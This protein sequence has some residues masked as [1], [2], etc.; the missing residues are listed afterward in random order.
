MERT[1]YRFSGLAN[2]ATV[3]AATLLAS[4][5]TFEQSGLPGSAASMAHNQIMLVRKEPQQTFGHY[6]L[7][8]LMRAYPDMKLFTEK[9][10]T[11]D[12]LAETSNQGQ[13]Y[14]ILY[15]LK[16]REAYAARTRPEQRALL[17]FAGPYPITDKEKQMLQ[18]L[19]N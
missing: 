16:K 8:S 6:R 11:P 7:V 4:C 17:E 15:Y 13:P 2:S 12:F 18:D 14:Y 19:R 1:K 10:G 3:L 5:S 9:N